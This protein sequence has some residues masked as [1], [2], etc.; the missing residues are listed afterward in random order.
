MRS[1]AKVAAQHITDNAWIYLSSGMTCYEIAK[2][3]TGRKL[4]VVAGGLETAIVLSQTNT[5]SVFVPGGA[6]TAMPNGCIL[7]GDWYLRSLDELRVEQA[8]ISVSG[9]DF[10][11]GY[12]VNNS[13]ELLHIKKLKEVS[14]ETIVVTDSTKFNH[15][16][17]LSAANL[18]YVDTVIT[19]RDIPKEY[20][21]FFNAH[22]VRLITD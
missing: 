17:F 8:F 16:A 1:L 10:I 5:L 4:N 9:V 12:S 18:D 2:L 13:S 14:R 7:S 15:Q 3:L 22:K 6:V 21:D 11:T 20:R 19:N